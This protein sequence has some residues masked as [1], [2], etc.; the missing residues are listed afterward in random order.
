MNNNSNNTTGPVLLGDSCYVYAK[1][2]Y[3]RSFKAFDLDGFFVGNLISAS[4]LL[5]DS[6][7]QRKLQALADKNKS[8]KL[9][10]QLRNPSDGKVVYETKQSA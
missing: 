3:M 1:S 6:E 10:F 7:N 2:K 9:Q 5:N 4:T 8:I